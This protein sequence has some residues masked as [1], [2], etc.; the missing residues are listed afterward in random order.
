MYIY[1]FFLIIF[2]YISTEKIDFS[3]IL[4]SPLVSVYNHVPATNLYR[5]LD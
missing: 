5:L 4:I 1:L 2:F 3:N